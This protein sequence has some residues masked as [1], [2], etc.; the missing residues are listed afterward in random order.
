M[1]D[2]CPVLIVDRLVPAILALNNAHATDL[3]WLNL[4][5]LETLIRQAFCARHI[6]KA[7]GFL[8]AFDE[9]ANY[10]SPNYLWFRQRHSKFIYIDRGRCSAQ[11]AWT[12]IRSLSV[13]RSL[14][15]YPLGSLSS[16]RLRGTLNRRTRYPMR[17]RP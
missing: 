7:G 12:W 9:T 3:S 5:Q 4:G 14:R 1:P 8:I 10:D 17:F 16:R 6:H 15:L 11:N 2:H 13:Q